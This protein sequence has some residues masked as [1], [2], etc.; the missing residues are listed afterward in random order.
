[1]SSAKNPSSAGSVNPGQRADELSD[2]KQAVRGLNRAP[3]GQSP[4]GALRGA[5]ERV[6]SFWW[7]E[8]LVGVMWVILATVVLKF[9]HASVTTVGILTGIMFLVFAAQQFILAAIDRRGRW[10]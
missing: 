4:V 8:L 1:M 9:N 3:G 5:L 10:I 2:L 7:V 6:T